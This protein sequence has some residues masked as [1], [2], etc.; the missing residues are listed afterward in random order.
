LS[1]EGSQESITTRNW[2]SLEFLKEMLQLAK[3]VVE[4]EKHVDPV[5]ER[6]RAKGSTNI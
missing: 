3:E 6:D 4:A 1:R 5:Q 2:T